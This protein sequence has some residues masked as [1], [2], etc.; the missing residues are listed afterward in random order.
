[1]IAGVFL[2]AA[3]VCDSRFKLNVIAALGIVVVYAVRA[4][5]RGIRAHACA[6]GEDGAEASS[7]G[8]ARKRG[9]GEPGDT[10]TGQSGTEKRPSSHVASLSV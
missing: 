7:R 8:G 6:G 10:G 4:L 3:G 2:R 1:M 9:R 5:H